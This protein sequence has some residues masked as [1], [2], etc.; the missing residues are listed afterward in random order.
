MELTFKKYTPENYSDYLRISKDHHINLNKVN[1]SDQYRESISRLGFLVGE[2]NSK[3]SDTLNQSIFHLCALINNKVVGL[4]RLDRVDRDLEQKGIT[5]IDSKEK[6][7]FEDGGQPDLG[8]IMVDRNYQ[9]Q[10]IAQKLLE[11]A[12]SFLQ[13]NH[14][15]HLFSF[16]VSRPKNI[17]SLAFH[18]KNGFKHIATY[19]SLEEFGIKDFESCLLVKNL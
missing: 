14:Y 13:E 6:Q 5:W 18:K 12:V 3:D 8:V 2:P 16:V 9:S 7:I 1:S 19:N 4:I 11:K 17:P 10:G 15:K